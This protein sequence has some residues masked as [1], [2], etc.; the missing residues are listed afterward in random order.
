VD[1]DCVGHEP[2]RP[3][4]GTPSRTAIQRD[5]G[6][7]CDSVDRGCQCSADGEGCTVVADGRSLLSLWPGFFGALLPLR[8][9]VMGDWFS[10]PMYGR[11][12]GTQWTAVVLVAAAGPVL[13]G[14]LRDTTGG[15]RAPF[16]SDIDVLVVSDAI[17]WPM[18]PS[19]LAS[20]WQEIEDSCFWFDH[21]IGVSV[22]AE[23]RYHFVAVDP[24]G[25]VVVNHERKPAEVRRGCRLWKD[26]RAVARVFE[27]A[28]KAL[29]IY[30]AGFFAG[31]FGTEWSTNRWA[32][33]DVG[34][35]PLT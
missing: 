5:V 34:G 27:S 28:Q 13:V 35:S 11:I 7:G 16:V 14:T 3:M 8:A 33:V 29:T 26:R 21:R 22:L 1:S 25:R 17:Q 31:D 30:V 12:V 18:R 2:A 19:G 15:Y 10:G 6:T 9:M 24:A 32:I 4:G 20:A 23:A